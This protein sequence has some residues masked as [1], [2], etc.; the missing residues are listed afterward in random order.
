MVF[1]HL[2]FKKWSASA[3]REITVVF[4]A[5]RQA[6]DCP[7]YAYGQEDTPKYRRFVSMF[8]FTPA[9][10]ITC[11]DGGERTLFISLKEPVG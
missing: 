4:N 10:T 11:N 7:L 3:L 5:L 9:S 8:G 1:V 6:L 2:R